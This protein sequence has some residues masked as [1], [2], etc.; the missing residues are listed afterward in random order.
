VEVI[1][2][3]NGYG[4]VLT[5]VEPTG[6]NRQGDDM[7]RLESLSLAQLAQLFVDVRSEVQGHLPPYCEPNLARWIARFGIG[8]FGEREFCR[9]AAELWVWR[10]GMDD[11]T[12]C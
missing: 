7:I 1:F 11:E 9:A 8:R 3:G 6:L 4:R 12:E 5:Q 10:K 2:Q